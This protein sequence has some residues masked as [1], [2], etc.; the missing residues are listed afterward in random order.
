MKISSSANQSLIKILVH[1]RSLTLSS[2]LLLMKVT[3]QHTQ[4]RKTTKCTNLFFYF[5]VIRRIIKNSL[6]FFLDRID[7]FLILIRTKDMMLIVLGAIN[8]KLTQLSV[9]EPLASL[10]INKPTGL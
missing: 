2:Y 4:Q 3:C 8:K 6:E 7:E 10:P 1:C 9:I 5:N